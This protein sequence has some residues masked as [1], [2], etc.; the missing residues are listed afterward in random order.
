MARLARLVIPHQAHHIT[1]AGI[2]GKTIFIDAQDYQAFLHWLKNAAQQYAVQIHAYSLLPDRLHLLATP[3][4]EL[5]L[6]KMM[7]WLGRYY[8]PYYN[9]KYQRSGLLWQGRFKATVLEASEFLLPCSLLIDEMPV[10]LGIC[11]DAKDYL[12]SSCR[13]QLGLH[14]DQLI[15]EHSMYW[16]LGNTPFQRE[17]AYRHLLELGLSSRHFQQINA[18]TQKS[19]LLGSD[20]YKTQMAQLT[21]RRVEPVRRGRPRKISN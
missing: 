9:Q 20:E 14:T 2:D 3:S 1:Q 18:A 17:A 19:W 11:Y 6:G 16:N 12:W 10:R 5:G 21:S 4:D 8:V 15:S 7:Q 13:H